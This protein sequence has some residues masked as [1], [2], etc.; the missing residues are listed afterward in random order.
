MASW[1][2]AVAVAASFLAA[3]AGRAGA[4]EI[5]GAVTDAGGGALPAV[6]VSLENVATGSQT[7]VATDA[8]GRFAFS[9]VPVGIYRI[10]ALGSGFSQE[11]RTISLA[12]RL[13][14]SFSRISSRR[15]VGRSAV[16]R[17]PI[18]IRSRGRSSVLRPM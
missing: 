13:T 5:R 10:S 3:S 18:V 6:D 1:K 9:S 12:A 15:S 4:A 2:Y 11:A 17:W 14:A 8:G 7:S 16:S